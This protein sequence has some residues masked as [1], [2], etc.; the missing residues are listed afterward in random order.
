[1]E[2]LEPRTLLSN[3]LVFSKTAAFRHDSIPDAI[4]AI[5]QMG[6]ESGFQVDATE[7]SSA[8]TDD[9]LSQYQAVVFL[10]T[11]GTVLDANQ[12]DAFQ[13]FIEAGNGYVGVHSASDTEYDWPWYG[14]LM[15]AYFSNHPN[16]QPAEIDVEDHGHPST[17]GLPDVW[18]RTDEWY[19]FQTNPRENVN[20]LATLDESTYTGGQMGDHPIMWYHDFDGGRAWYTGMGHTRESYSEKLFLQSL[21]GGI[22]YAMG[23]AGSSPSRPHRPQPTGKPANAPLRGTDSRADLSVAVSAH[24]HQDF[25]VTNLTAD[26]SI[27]ATLNPDLILTAHLSHAFGGMPSFS[28]P[29]HPR[30]D[31]TA[32]HPSVAGGIGGMHAVAAVPFPGWHKPG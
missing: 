26:A 28:S 6:A 10:L 14:Q 2:T 23:T 5:Q 8:F 24:N 1:V 30:V 13:R 20:V 19:N 7:D 12:K 31:G 27:A 29:D 16:I 4:A 9:N 3:L 15:G 32:V 21:L 22:E 17:Q 18:P 11:T 25:A